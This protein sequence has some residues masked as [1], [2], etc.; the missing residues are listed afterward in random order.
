M[1]RGNV[2]IFWRRKLENCYRINRISI[3]FMK[4]SKERKRRLRNLIVKLFRNAHKVYTQVVFSIMWS[5]R[6]NLRLQ[7][8]PIWTTVKKIQIQ[9]EVTIKT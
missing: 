1:L 2:L 9:V 3:L 7:P 6:L 8:R 5:H 4:K